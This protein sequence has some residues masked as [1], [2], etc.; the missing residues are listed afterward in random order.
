MKVNTMSYD[1]YAGVDVGKSFHHLH[2]TDHVGKVLVSKRIDQNEDQLLTMFSNLSQGRSVLVVVDQPR[3]IGSL[4]LQCARQAGCQVAYL[5]GLAMRRAA[6]L[7]PG[8]AKTD[9]RD[10]QVIAMAAR[11]I[12]EALRPAPNLDE[13]RGELEALAGYD[14]DCQTDRTREI[15]R[16]RALL[17]ETNPEF[18]KAL[19]DD[20]ASL[21][22]LDMLIKYGGPWSIRDTSH[23]KIQRWASKRSHTSTKLLER[24]MNAAELMTLRPPGWHIREHLS[25]PACA[26]RIRELTTTHKANE[27]HLDAL[28][29]TDPTYQALLTMPGIGPKT[30]ATLITL[31]NIDQFPDHEKLA[32]YCGLAG[33]TTQSGTSI[34]GESASRAGNRTLK[35][36]L[37]LS[38]FASLRCDPKAREFYDAKRAAGKQHNTTIIALARKRLK[39][40]YAIMRD[41]TPYQA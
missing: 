10:A 20:I 12:P 15:N 23:T 13:I 39:I 37:F 28:L 18:E 29:T 19:G 2:A 35:N 31:V 25:I 4:T 22:T 14:N 16:L 24:I 33:R 1:V 6:G 5:P 8:D 3:N 30:A 11:T 32:S 38:A 34:K 26:T 41:K 21:L 40:I 9:A 27:K 36:A 17:V 7:L